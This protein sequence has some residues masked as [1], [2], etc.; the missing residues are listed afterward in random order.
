M[1]RG[2]YRK[3]EHCGRKYWPKLWNLADLRVIVSFFVQAAQN[4]VYS[5]RLKVQAFC[6]YI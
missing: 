2:M 3:G 6:S 4:R 5:V 1:A